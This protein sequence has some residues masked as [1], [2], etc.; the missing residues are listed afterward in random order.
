MQKL[1]FACFFGFICFSLAQNNSDCSPGF[2]VDNED[3]C[4]PCPSGCYLCA[5][6]YSC[7]T[8]NS[9]LT[10]SYNG[11]CGVKDCENT[12]CVLCD[13]E[14]PSICYQCDDVTFLDNESDC[15]TC[16]A[17]CITCDSSTYCDMCDNEYEL[18]D[19]G[20]CIDPS[21]ICT[22][23][24]SC[25]ANCV[26]CVN[27]SVCADCPS[28][29]YVDSNGGCSPCIQ[30]CEICTD[31][32]TCSFCSLGWG[33]DDNGGCS[34]CPQNCWS[35]DYAAQCDQCLFNWT[36]DS[37]GNCL[38]SDPT[39]SVSDPEGYKIIIPPSDSP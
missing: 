9:G 11:Y 2:G 38:V 12:D 3:N 6:S 4:Q 17:N 7:D 30:D 13:A 23:G 37:E 24:C 32:S 27:T 34:A 22:Q 39:S 15:I 29:T 35:C 26:T 33:L 1:F 14:D 5:A 31:S 19:N 36:W 8:C 21:T 10:L 20:N 16:P 25:S 28:G 18:L